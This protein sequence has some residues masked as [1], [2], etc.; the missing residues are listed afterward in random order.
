MYQNLQN[1]KESIQ[2][3]S[4]FGSLGA[5]CFGQVDRI[6]IPACGSY[7]LKRIMT[8]PSTEQNTLREAKIHRYVHFYFFTN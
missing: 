5:G 3:F 2:E 1:S 6:S 8:T 7:A 4:V